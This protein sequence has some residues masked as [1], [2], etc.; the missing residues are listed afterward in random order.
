[1]EEKIYSMCDVP[2]WERLKTKEEKDE[3]CMKRFGITF[4]EYE[5]IIDSNRPYQEIYNEILK[6]HST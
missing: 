1:M 3:Y 5:E 4:D 2:W 6:R